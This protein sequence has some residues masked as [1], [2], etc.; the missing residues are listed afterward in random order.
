VTNDVSP[1]RHLV[2]VLSVAVSY[3]IL[4]KSLCLSQRR[5]KTLYNMLRSLPF[6][7]VRIVGMGGSNYFLIYGGSKR[8]GECKTCLLE[9]LYGLSVGLETLIDVSLPCLNVH[10]IRTG[11]SNYFLANNR[12]SKRYDKSLVHD[13]PS[14]CS[15]FL[16]SCSYF[17]LQTM[18]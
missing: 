15:E 12:G 17:L 18:Q 10:I 8:G 2:F 6:V 16:C 9:L 4:F 13:F 14:A 3:K 11:G 1:H 5:K 7:D